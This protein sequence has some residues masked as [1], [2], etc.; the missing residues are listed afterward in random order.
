M[1]IGAEQD[2]KLEDY[3]ALLGGSTLPTV[4]SDIVSSG[5]SGQCLLAP[6]D[7]FRSI[8][9]VFVS[10]LFLFLLLL[11]LNGFEEKSDY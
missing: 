11:V 5:T 7:F 10:I 3:T 9:F 2:D 8:V 6:Y 1:V 4:T